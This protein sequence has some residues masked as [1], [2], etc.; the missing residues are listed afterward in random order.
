MNHN[1]FRRYPRTLD[2]AFPFGPRYGCA[3]ERPH[4]TRG[5]VILGCVIF[6]VLYAVIFFF[7]ISK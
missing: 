2:E 7:G 3:I 4:Q 6:G 5:T 1:N